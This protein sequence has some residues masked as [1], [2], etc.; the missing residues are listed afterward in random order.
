MDTRLYWTLPM[1]L[2]GLDAEVRIRLLPVLGQNHD[3]WVSGFV[4]WGETCVYLSVQGP[5]KFHT[6]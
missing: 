5:H 2:V 4:I 3:T 6:T 1:F